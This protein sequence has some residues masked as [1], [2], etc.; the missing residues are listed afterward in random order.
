M[1]RWTYSP[2]ARLWRILTGA[3]EPEPERHYFHLLEDIEIVI[4]WGRRRYDIVGHKIVRA[5]DE[6]A[7]WIRHLARAQ[8]AQGLVKNIDD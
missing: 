3:P 4:D 7:L 5:T 2:L 8:K 1:N 6:Q